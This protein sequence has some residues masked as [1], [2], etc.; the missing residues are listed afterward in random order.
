ME[1]SEFR[2][3]ALLKSGEGLSYVEAEDY[4]NSLRT[5]ESREA[6]RDVFGRFPQ[7]FGMDFT[8]RL[9]I[10]GYDDNL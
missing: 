9:N 3:N 2:L 1:Q 7:L 8:Y 6:V 4:I 10:P 5:K